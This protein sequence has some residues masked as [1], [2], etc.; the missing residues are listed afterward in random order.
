[1]AT[2]TQGMAP[3]LNLEAQAT[4]GRFFDSQNPFQQTCLFDLTHQDLLPEGYGVVMMAA[5]NQEGQIIPIKERGLHLAYGMMIDPDSPYKP[6]GRSDH[7]EIT[8]FQEDGSIALAIDTRNRAIGKYT[9]QLTESGVRGQRAVTVLTVTPESLQAAIVVYDHQ[10][11][12][13]K[14]ADMNDATILYPSVRELANHQLTKNNAADLR[15]R[16]IKLEDE[17]ARLEIFGPNEFGGKLLQ[18]KKDL[19]ARQLKELGFT[20][21][22]PLKI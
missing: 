18:K 11:L 10:G 1:M 3:D 20:K 21:F 4:N 7:L 19:V 12:L 13:R 17:Q 14:Q 8:G 15:N 22:E 9:W 6:H 16:R 5:V 2:L